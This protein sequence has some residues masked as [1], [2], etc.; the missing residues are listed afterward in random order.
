MFNSFIAQLYFFAQIIVVVAV[1]VFL[2]IGVYRDAMK[3]TLKGSNTF[4]A[5]PLIWSAATL[6]GGVLPVLV[7]WLIHHFPTQAALLL[8]APRPND[9]PA[10]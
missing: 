7:Y 9:D 1:H 10:E 5:P 6:I 8:R 4:A 2:A 3:L